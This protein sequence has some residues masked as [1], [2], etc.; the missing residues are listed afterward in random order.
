MT[1][2]LNTNWVKLQMALLNKSTTNIIKKNN[3]VYIQN[4]LET[5]FKTINTVSLT[6]CKD[7]VNRVSWGSMSTCSDQK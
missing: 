3:W 1:C 6:G 2:N 4:L 7:G 5:Y